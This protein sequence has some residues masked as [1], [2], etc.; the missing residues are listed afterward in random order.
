MTQTQVQ[1][2]ACPRPTIGLW[3]RFLVQVGGSYNLFKSESIKRIDNN[4]CFELKI[5][6]GGVM[7]G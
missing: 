6:L 1:P 3:C 7:A 4:Y 2:K 5:I